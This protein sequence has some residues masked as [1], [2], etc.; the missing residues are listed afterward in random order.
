MARDAPAGQEGQDGGEYHGGHGRIR[1]QDK[2]PGRPEHGVAN[3][4]A[5]RRVEAGNGGQAGKFGV[6]HALR[7]E[8]GGQDDAGHNVRPAQARW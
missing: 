3:Q 5:D 7:N 4:T 2:D 1:P 8:D 6:G